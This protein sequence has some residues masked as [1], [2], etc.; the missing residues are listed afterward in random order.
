MK[1][2]DE[3]PRE[4]RPTIVVNNPPSPNGTPKF[5]RAFLEIQLKDPKLKPT[6]KMVGKLRPSRLLFRR[7]KAC[8]A[9]LL[10]APKKW[11]GE[12]ARRNENFPPPES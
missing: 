12:G 1:V 8:F 7:Q 10:I 3:V 9:T 5:N 11:G 6:G 4:I 2:E